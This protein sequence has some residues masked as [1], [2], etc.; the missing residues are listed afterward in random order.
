M[1]LT[2]KYKNKNKNKKGGF[3]SFKKKSPA[4]LTIS[5]KQQSFTNKLRSK[6]SEF[7]GINVKLEKEV[8]QPSSKIMKIVNKIMQ[9]LN[10]PIFS[11]ILIF[12]V[13][14]IILCLK[15]GYNDL[16]HGYS[17]EETKFLLQRY[18]KNKLFMKQYIK[19]FSF[20]FY[21]LFISQQKPKTR[22]TKFFY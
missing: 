7:I 14:L 13:P 15:Q 3:F 22:L 18:Q 1:K 11:K 5:P 21:T 10:D 12:Y 20:F 4:K 17:E 19:L 8:E 16:K 6:L 9:I 2:Y